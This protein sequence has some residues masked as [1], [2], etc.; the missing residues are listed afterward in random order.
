M[1]YARAFFST[2]TYIRHTTKAFRVV[3]NIIYEYVH[4]TT[5]TIPALWRLFL[6]CMSCRYPLLS[7]ISWWINIK[8]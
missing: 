3:Y 8:K 2:T 7:C 1:I 5:T 4:K 6:V